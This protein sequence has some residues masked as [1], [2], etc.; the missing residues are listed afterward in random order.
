MEGRE[1][2]EITFNAGERPWVALII[3]NGP[4]Y[5]VEFEHGCSLNEQKVSLSLSVPSYRPW[6]IK[7]S[8]VGGGIARV[9]EIEDERE[10]AS[11]EEFSR[12]IA[13]ERH[14]EPSQKKAS[15]DYAHWET[16]AVQLHYRDVL[17]KLNG[18]IDPKAR[19]PLRKELKIMAKILRPVW[20]QESKENPISDEELCRLMIEK[21]QG[22]KK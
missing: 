22:T 7:I 12:M 15:P 13:S 9:K 6:L 3:G 4:T 21:S 18:T 14:L 17:D 19:E 5:N 10:G 1:K 20:E 11:F 16:K 2:V 8:G